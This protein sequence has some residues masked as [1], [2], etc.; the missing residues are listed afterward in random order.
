MT[1]NAIKTDG[2]LW[3]WGYNNLGGLGHNDVVSRS[4]PVQVGTDTTWS[5]VQNCSD[6]A[7]SKALKTD[8]TLWSWGNNQ[9]GRLGL[10]NLV[11][12]SSPVQVG[13]ATNWSLLSQTGAIKTIE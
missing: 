3:S 1:L 5:Q 9:F 7:T 10:N 13:T 8:G 12:Y 6:Y 4:S 11:Q 2:T